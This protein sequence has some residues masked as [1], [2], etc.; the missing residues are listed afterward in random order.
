MTL[1]NCSVVITGNDSLEN[2]N[3]TMLGCFMFTDNAA[4]KVLMII[5]YSVVILGSI[6][7]NISLAFVYF[8]NKGM[9]NTVNSCIMNMVFADLLVTIVYM[10][11]MVA[12]I[13]VGLEWMAEGTLGLALCKI[14]S[15]SQEISMCVSILTVVIIAFERFFAIAFPLR[16]VISKKLSIGLLSG[17]WL[18]SLAARSPMFYAVKTITFNSGTRGC[19]WIHSVSFSTEKARMFYHG[20]MLIAFYGLPLLCIITLYTAIL[21]FLRRRQTLIGNTTRNRA[22]ATNKKVTQM[23]LTVIAAFLLCWLLYFLVIP[24]EEFWN[25]DIS[26]EIHFLRLFLGHI[27]SACNPIICFVFSENF[28]NGIKRCRNGRKTRKKAGRNMWRRTATRDR[29]ISNIALLS[30]QTLAFDSRF[31]YSKG[32]Y[33]NRF[34]YDEN[35]V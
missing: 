11:R 31:Q 1:K 21:I 19:I 22:L 3:V 24:M 30:L 18:V 16:E 8:T 35:S 23:I 26:C 5:G 6:V 9:K 14:V 10:P 15:I 25:V 34:Q 27:N 2:I 17:S 33:N 4:L 32:V 12:R 13:L 29:S 20:F 28:K 7:G